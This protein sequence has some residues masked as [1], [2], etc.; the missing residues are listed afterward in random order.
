MLSFSHVFCENKNTAISCH[1]GKVSWVW[2]TGVQ[3]I[4][5]ARERRLASRIVWRSGLLGLPFILTWTPP[6]FRPLS[7]CSWRFLVPTV[8]A[9]GVV[10]TRPGTYSKM[11]HSSSSVWTCLFYWYLT[12]ISG[13]IN[14]T[15]YEISGE[16]VRNATAS[17]SLFVVVDNPLKGAFTATCWVGVWI[18][19]NRK[20]LD[21]V[22]LSDCG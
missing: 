15:C 22:R 11:R 17:S 4:A 8:A 20:L 19:E 5:Q 1:T 18:D 21:Y 13:D 12:G 16:T 10:V 9:G 14:A 6:R 2:Y 3:F 7:E